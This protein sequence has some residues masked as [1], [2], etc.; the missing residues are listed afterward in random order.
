VIYSANHYHTVWRDKTADYGG[1]F[2]F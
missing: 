2:S 1:N